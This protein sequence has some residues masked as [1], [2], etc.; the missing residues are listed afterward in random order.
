MWQRMLAALETVPYRHCRDLD[1]LRRC[2]SACF[3]VLR[4]N[5]T[6]AELGGLVPS[7]EAAKKRFRRWAKRGVFDRL[8]ECSQPVAAPAVLHIDSTGAF[9]KR[10]AGIKCHR[11]A[12]GARGGGDECIGRSRGGLTT[13]AHHAVDGLGFIRR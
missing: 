10:D 8:M 13:K 5:L 7:A 4:T 6:W 1:R 12:A 11:P 3:A 9:A 2:T